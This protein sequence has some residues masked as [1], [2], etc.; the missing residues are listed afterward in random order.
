[1]NKEYEY[2]ETNLKL[3]KQQKRDKRRADLVEKGLREAKVSKKR[4]LAQENEVKKPNQQH[5]SSLPRGIPENWNVP[6]GRMMAKGDENF[7]EVLERS[8]TGFRID[9]PEVF[10]RDFH[11]NMQKSLRMLTYDFDIVQPLGLNT[12]LAQTMV[13]RVLVGAEGM[14]YKYLGIRMFSIPFEKEMERCNSI[15]SKRTRELAK[16]EGD[17]EYNLVLINQCLPQSKKVKLKFEPTFKDQKVPQSISWHADSMLK[18]FSSIACYHWQ[19]EIEVGNEPWQIGL[20][21][22][23]HSEG[24]TKNQRDSGVS[25][26]PWGE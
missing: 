19:P 3:T 26:L 13:K 23:P 6:N 1:M 15:L 11:E 8:Y 14:T 16:S 24:P 22:E 10:D 12:P 9:Q 4:R 25:M 20:R 2:K 17:E 21:V 18:H 7:T 5:K